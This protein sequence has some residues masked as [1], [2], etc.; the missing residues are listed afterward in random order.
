M[1]TSTLARPEKAAISDL[2]LNAFTRAE[3]EEQ[4]DSYLFA[5][6]FGRALGFYSPRAPAN[7]WWYENGE[8]KRAKMRLSR[9]EW[10]EA[11]FKIQA[12][13]GEVISLILNRAQR[14]LEC[15]ILRMERAGLPVRLIILKARQMG[16]STYVQAVMFEKILRGERVRGLIVADTRERSEILLSMAHLGNTEMPKPEWLQGVRVEK[17]STNAQ[18]K[19]VFGKDDDNDGKWLFRMRSKAS[20]ALVWDDPL[21][22][23]IKVTSAEVEAPGRGGTRQLLHMSESAYWMNAQHKAAGVLGSLPKLPGTYAFNESTANGAQGWFY[24]DFWRGWKE[25]DIRLESRVFP[26]VSLFFAWFEHEEYYWTKAWGQG[27]ELTE[28]AKKEIVDTLD[29]EEEWLL[30]Q[31]YFRRW[32]P[33]DEWIKVKRPAVDNPRLQVEVWA[34]KDVGPRKVG[35]DQIKWRRMMIQ[36][37]EIHNDLNKFRQE[38][39]ATPEEA[40]LSSGRTVFDHMALEKMRRAATGP[41]WRGELAEPIDSSGR[42]VRPVPAS[43]EFDP[44]VIET[45]IDFDPD[46]EY[47]Q[48]E[49]YRLVET[50]Y[51]STYVWS[52]PNPERAYI[53]AVDAAGGGANGDYA[54]AAVIDS[55]TCALVAAVHDRCAPIPFGR[56]IAR[57]AW[58]YNEALLAFETYPSGHGLSAC[59]SAIHYGYQRMYKRRNQSTSSKDMSEELGWHTSVRT[60]D[61]M[62]G[63]I[64]EAVQSGYDMPFLILIE[65]LLA[66]RYDENGKIVCQGHDDMMDAYAIGLLVRDEAWR[67]GL[68]VKPKPPPLDE[69]ARFWEAWDRRKTNRGIETRRLR[70]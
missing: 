42:P 8:L 10:I 32:E 51:G 44:M 31:S 33:K 21:Q 58:Y 4:A 11:N 64:T 61:M 43:L 34:R 46:K 23:T 60:K 62:I 1:T 65:Q 26:W 47:E 15:W 22:G 54:C 14:R 59:H 37:P 69:T 66:Q 2:V 55:E 7:L 57:L 25:R 17:T 12:K 39:P 67:R 70:F 56:R 36:D 41:I 19:V 30:K 48:T 53:I 9:R 50:R 68:V 29:E 3:R 16:F 18:P 49:F 52:P 27:K 24:D 20:N 35:L 63:R 40:F 28:K 38:Y 6:V 5:S 45:P 13:T